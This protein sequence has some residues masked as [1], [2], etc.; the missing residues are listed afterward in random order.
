MLSN[1]LQDANKK[2]DI[3]KLWAPGSYKLV[4]LHSLKKP[5]PIEHMNNETK[6]IVEI[7]L[8]SIKILLMEK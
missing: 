3:D 7:S 1:E 2:L 8:L 4:E 6:E 5:D